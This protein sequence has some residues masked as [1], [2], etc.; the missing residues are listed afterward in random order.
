M[1]SNSNSIIHGTIKIGA[2][3]TLGICVV[4]TQFAYASS[5]PNPVIL[6]Y[7]TFN[8][9]IFLPMS[10]N[11]E[12]EVEES[13]KMLESN[14]YEKKL[15]SEMSASDDLKSTVPFDFELPIPFP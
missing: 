12:S 6:N 3:F 11:I 8:G 4:L 5:G 7:L 10:S 15:S 9:E 2:I 1:Y 14:I 13:K